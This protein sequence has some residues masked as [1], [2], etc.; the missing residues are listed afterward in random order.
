MKKRSKYKPKGVRLDAMSW[1]LA[2][3]KTITEVPHAGVTLKIKNHA[4]MTDMVAGNGTRDSV[5]VLIAAMNIA[6]ALTRLG[7]GDDWSAEIRQA[8]DALLNMGRRGVQKGDRFLFTGSELTAMN[9]GM[10]I[11]DAQLEE[12]TVKQMEE[13]LNIVEREIRAKKA[14]T[15]CVKEAA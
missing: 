5:D 11:H 6:E 9:L 10:D 1:V 12:C 15:V 8:Q 3:M 7:I 13:A 2:G 14:R 4:A